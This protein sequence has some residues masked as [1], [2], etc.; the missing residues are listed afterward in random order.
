M[1]ATKSI[2]HFAIKVLRAFA[3]VNLICCLVFSFLILHEFGVSF[4]MEEELFN[5]YT[6]K[7][8]NPFAITLSMAS[9]LMAIFGW[10]FCLV[11]AHMA[12]NLIA[13]RKN[14]AGPPPQGD[15]EILNL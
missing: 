3:W 13:L 12:E 2:D 6:E 7:V 1:N 8:I 14:D 10:A 15:G 4:V 5:N 9:F 11:V